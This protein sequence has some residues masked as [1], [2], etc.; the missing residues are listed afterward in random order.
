MARCPHRAREQ[1]YGNDRAHDL[2]VVV[3]DAAGQELRERRRARQHEGQHHDRGPLAAATL[4]FAH[5]EARQKGEQQ[6]RP[7][8]LSREFGGRQIGDQ[9]Q[10]KDH[11]C[12]AGI[13]EPRPVRGQPLRCADPIKMR[14]EPVSV[15]QEL[16]DLEQAE[17]VIGVAKGRGERIG[18]W[19]QQ[20][21]RSHQHDEG[22][23]PAPP[24]RSEPA[25]DGD[26]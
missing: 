23:S 11:R 10:H 9:R 20:M 16:A 25:R 22:E 12:Q 8:D 7:D 17:G 4:G 24:R 3:I 21:T 5:D 26:R 1:E 2:D 6:E 19:A 15:R 14:V 13:D 18:G